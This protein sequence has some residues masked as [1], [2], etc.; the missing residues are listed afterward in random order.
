MP[1]DGRCWRLCGQSPIVELAEKQYERIAP[2]LP[3]ARGD[4]KC[5]SAGAERAAAHGRAGLQVPRL[6]GALRSLSHG[7]HAARPLAKAGVLERVSAA[8]L[9]EQLSTQDWEALVLGHHGQP[10]AP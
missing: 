3:C 4:T 10:T 5:R 1:E 2:L 9:A 8:L 6:A 7:R